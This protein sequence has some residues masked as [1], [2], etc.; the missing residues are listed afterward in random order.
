LV[1]FFPDGADFL[2]HPLFFME[3]QAQVL[4]L[5]HRTIAI[6]E[7]FKERYEK[8]ITSLKREFDID[9]LITGDISQVDG[10]PNWI[11]E[12]SIPSKMNV[13]TPLWGL[14]RR[15]NLSRLVSLGFQVIFSGVKSPWLTEDWLGREITKDAIEELYSREQETGLDLCGEQGEYHTLVLDGPPFKQRIEIN[16]FS[17][18]INNNMT[19]MKIEDWTLQDK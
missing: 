10:H 15:V 1:T 3:V 16:H 12:C 7:P 4:G 19:Y 17:K 9:T 18:R 5:S 13:L 11:R 14:D 6:S 8:A 2:A